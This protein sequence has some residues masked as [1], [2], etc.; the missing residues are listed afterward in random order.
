MNDEVKQ[1]ETIQ[2]AE[3]QESERATVA[4]A[5][6]R[7]SGPPAAPAGE[8]R[9]DDAARQPARTTSE[10]RTE[11]A[12]GQDAGDP[13]AE[14]S[15]AAG[16]VPPIPQAGDDEN[17]EFRELQQ[18]LAEGRDLSQELEPPAAGEGGGTGDSIAAGVRFERD[19]NAREYQPGRRGCG[20]ATSEQRCG[21]QWSDTCRRGR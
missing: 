20:T 11:A 6:Q 3:Q 9:D 14:G 2:S 10:T 8:R 16:Q 15:A 4:Q 17:P 21:D 18:A 12:A 1:G 19:P 7:D 13:V 5:A